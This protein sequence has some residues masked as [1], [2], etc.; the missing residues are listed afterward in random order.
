MQLAEF[1]QRPERLVI[2]P[3][4]VVDQD[5]RE[6][7]RLLEFAD[8]PGRRLR[9]IDTGPAERSQVVIDRDRAPQEQHFQPQG[10]GKG[11]LRGG[12]IGCDG[13]GP[14]QDADGLV[15][16]VLVDQ[17]SR[18]G[19]QGISRLGLWCGVSGTRPEQQD[20]HARGRWPA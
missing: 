11:V 17:L 14:P 16:L 10:T 18:P 9:E 15:V 20:G 7:D 3:F 6:H 13:D 5:E 2:A 4:T 8:E 1:L 19:T 12:L